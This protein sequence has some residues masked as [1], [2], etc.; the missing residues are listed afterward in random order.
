VEG[1][2]AGGA[3]RAGFEASCWGINKMPAKEIGFMTFAP[4]SVNYASALQHPNQQDH[5]RQHQQ[6]VD[7]STHRVRGDDPQQPQNHQDHKDCPK[8]VC[9]FFLLSC[10]ASQTNRLQCGVPT[11]S[12]D[13][14]I[15]SLD[16]E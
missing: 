1:G 14:T 7:E 10:A 11:D 15:A 5:D 2:V 3:G 12:Q 9:P 8:H 6:N 4:R 16:A 13:K